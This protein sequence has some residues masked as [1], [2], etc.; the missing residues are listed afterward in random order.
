MVDKLWLRPPDDDQASWKEYDPALEPN[1][2]LDLDK[3]TIV[4]SFL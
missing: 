2:D 3:T 4:A 1:R